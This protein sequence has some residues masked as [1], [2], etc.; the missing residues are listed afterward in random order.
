MA[1]ERDIEALVRQA[2]A[3]LPGLHTKSE[4]EI[5]WKKYY[6][7]LGHRRLGQLMI[8]RTADNILRG[9]SRGGED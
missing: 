1:E 2:A 4:V 5:W 8:G 7:V 9:R 3:E 6:L